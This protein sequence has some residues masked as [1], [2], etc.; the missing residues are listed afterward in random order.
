[1]GCFGEGVGVLMTVEDVLLVYDRQIVTF[2]Y[3]LVAVGSMALIPG[4]QPPL[5]QA[6]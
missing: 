4:V 2:A 3:L 6:W 1:M 5:H